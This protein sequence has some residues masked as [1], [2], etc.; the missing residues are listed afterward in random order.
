MNIFISSS[1]ALSLFAKSPALSGWADSPAGAIASKVLGYVTVLLLLPHCFVAF[2][3]LKHEKYL[4][5]I[6]ANKGFLYFVI[7]A[8]HAL[9]GP[10]KSILIPPRP[11]EVEA[12]KTD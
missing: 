7:I 4:P 12:K 10:L 9:K 3:L 2:P 8:W 5:V 6:L 1:Q 11:K